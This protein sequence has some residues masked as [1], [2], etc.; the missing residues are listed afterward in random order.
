MDL[1]LLL[2]WGTLALLCFGCSTIPAA[3]QG[4][5]SIGGT[6]ADK[7]GAV[8]PGSTVT[9]A[10][11]RGTIGSNQTAVTDERGAFQFTRLVPGAY[12][13]KA[14]LA[15]FTTAV[16]ENVVVNADVTARVD[17]RL[18]IGGLAEDITVT[19]GAPLLDTTSALRQDRKS[20]V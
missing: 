7:S 3:A 5:G 8:L 18:E 20:V 14:E 6:I 10:S 15:G 1:R 4:V 9:L 19:G 11:P 2:R 12:S 13:V 17:F 16:Q